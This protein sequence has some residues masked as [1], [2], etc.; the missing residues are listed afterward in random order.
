MSARNRLS[1]KCSGFL[2]R[3]S[4]A[5]LAARTRHR[6]SS[7]S[8]AAFSITSRPPDS[9]DIVPQL[10]R[11][12]YESLSYLVW[13][14]RRLKFFGRDVRSLKLTLPPTRPAH[15]GFLRPRY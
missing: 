3:S 15:E 11:L 1:T 9:L 4:F 8:S 7:V 2:L 13:P 14:N 5:I 6:F 10:L 12:T